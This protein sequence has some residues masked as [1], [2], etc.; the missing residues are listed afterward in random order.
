MLPAERCY[1][2]GVEHEKVDKLFQVCYI[3]AKKEVFY[4]CNFRLS[5]LYKI[6]VL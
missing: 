6:S 2:V 3:Y 4:I 1:L 5:D